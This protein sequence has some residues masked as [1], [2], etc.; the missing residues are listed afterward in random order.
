MHLES[1]GS[2][3][4]RGIV[5]SVGMKKAAGNG[6]VCDLAPLQACHDNSPTDMSAGEYKNP[7][8]NT[9]INFPTEVDSK[10]SPSPREDTIE[11]LKLGINAV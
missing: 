7:P 9:K 11:E 10:R 2:K 6:Y 8:E 3:I 1:T 4:Y 5:G